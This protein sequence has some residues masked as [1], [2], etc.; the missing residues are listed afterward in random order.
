MRGGSIVYQYKSTHGIG[1]G[2]RN[3]ITSVDFEVVIWKNGRCAK[4]G[5]QYCE[6][7]WINYALLGIPNRL[8]CI[9][10][11]YPTTHI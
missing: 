5:I 1:V 3:C 11:L 2:S 4:S 8:I 7:H 10:G 6:N 9:E